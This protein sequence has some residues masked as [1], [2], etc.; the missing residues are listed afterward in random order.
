VRPG[1]IAEVVDGLDIGVVPVASW[2]STR[3]RIVLRY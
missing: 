3:Q 2:S 1:A